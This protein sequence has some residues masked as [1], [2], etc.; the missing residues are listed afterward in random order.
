MPPESE[1]VLL[2]KVMAT[3]G[4]RGQLRIFLFSGEFSSIDALDRVILMGPDREMDTFEVAAAAQHGKKFLLT[5]KK[6]DNVNQVL[7][8][9][10]RELYVEREQLP[11]LPR[12]E[13]YWRDLV[14]L[15]VVTDKGEELGTLT[16]IIATGSNDVYVV[17]G[18]EREY[19][20]PALEDVVLEVDLDGGV[21][22]VSPLEGLLDL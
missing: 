17:T 22:K 6:Y 5:L 2:G 21:M 19:L 9:V 7:H 20:I 8:L 3:H 15:R 10:G 18:K 16:D 12:G 14:G 4:V 1:L 11:E 13:Y